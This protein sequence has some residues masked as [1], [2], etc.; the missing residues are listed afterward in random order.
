MASTQDVREMFK[1]FRILV[2]G[3]AMAGKTTLQ[4]V[5]SELFRNAAWVKVLIEHWLQYA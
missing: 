4:S 5:W 1:R 3:R 2:V